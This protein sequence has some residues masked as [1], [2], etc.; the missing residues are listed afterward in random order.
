MFVKVNGNFSSICVPYEGV[1][2]SCFDLTQMFFFLD[3]DMLVGGI[4]RNLLFWV[5]QNITK[6]LFVNMQVMQKI[7]E[8]SSLICLYENQFLSKNQ[9]TQNV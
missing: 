6:F 8:N 5:A 1:T 3:T 9:N 7:E 4:I 2:L